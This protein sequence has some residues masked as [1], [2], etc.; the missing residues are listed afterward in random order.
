M[1]GPFSSSQTVS[2]YQRVK[3]VKKDIWKFPG[4]LAVGES[5]RMSPAFSLTRSPCQAQG[6]LLLD[7]CNP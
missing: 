7:V 4:G 6:F 1:T 5:D 3:P 2:H